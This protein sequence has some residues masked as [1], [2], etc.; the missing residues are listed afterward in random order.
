MIYEIE[1][2][3]QTPD[4]TNILRKMYEEGK[5]MECSR[6]GTSK[7]DYDICVSY[8]E[9]PSIDMIRHKPLCSD[10]LH[11]IKND[12]EMQLYLTGKVQ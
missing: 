8:S 7:W 3:E 9:Q 5:M 12:E 10:C 2:Q 1:H 11:A 6:C 4:L